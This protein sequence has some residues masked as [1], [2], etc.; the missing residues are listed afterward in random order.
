M[1]FITVQQKY[2]QDSKHLQLTTLHP[3]SPFAL[4]S[5]QQICDDR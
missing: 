4:S 5:L 2:F 1:K 3:E